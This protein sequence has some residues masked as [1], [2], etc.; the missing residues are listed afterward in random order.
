MPELGRDLVAELV[1]RAELPR[2]VDVQQRE[3]RLATD[4]TPSRA[5]CSITELSLPI[6]YSITGRSLSATA[7]RMM[8]MLSASSRC[9]WV[10]APTAGGG[11][12]ST[13]MRSGP[14][15]LLAAAIP[16][17]IRSASSGRQTTRS[18]RYGPGLVVLQRRPVD[19]AG[20]QPRPRA[21][22]RPARPSPTPTGRR[23]ARTRRPRRGR[24]PSSWLRPSPSAPLQAE[25]GTEP[26][27]EARRRESLTSTRNGECAAVVDRVAAGTDDDAER[28]QRDRG[29]GDL[30]AV[31]PQRRRAPP[32]PSGPPCRTH[33]CRRAGR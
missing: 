2:R 9:R 15:R 4:G 6:E 23:R 1:H 27:Q 5:R 26:G 18:G 29:G 14:P 30:R 3:R 8:W 25:P 32:S 31:L 24:R 7:S 28:G 16:A 13:V 20:V 10:S 12:E 33:G 22:P 11:V 17:R 19:P 21:R